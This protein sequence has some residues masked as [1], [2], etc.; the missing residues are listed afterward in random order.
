MQYRLRV[1]AVHANG[2]LGG[3]V[4]S[5]WLHTLSAKAL[6]NAPVRLSLVRQRLRDAQ[7]CAQVAWLPDPHYPSCF[8]H[9]IWMDDQRIQTRTF[10]VVRFFAFAE[11]ARRCT[12]LLARRNGV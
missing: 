2:T 4:A 5:D 7:L 6:L 11:G 9:L 12:S 10:A 3:F 1:L 8:Y